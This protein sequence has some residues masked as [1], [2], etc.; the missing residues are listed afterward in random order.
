[1]DAEDEDELVQIPGARDLLSAY[2]LLRWMDRFPRP[3][4]NLFHKF[5]GGA[6]IST[7][8]NNLPFLRN[9]GSIDGSVIEEVMVW[10]HPKKPVGMLQSL[11]IITTFIYLLCN[12]NEM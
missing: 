6:F 3:V 12:G 4:F 11:M 2:F 9:L 5:Q 1:M 10:P 7:M 8:F